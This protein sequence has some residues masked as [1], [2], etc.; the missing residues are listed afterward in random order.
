[1]LKDGLGSTRRMFDFSTTSG[2]SSRVTIIASRISDGKACVIANYRGV[3]PRPV[4]AVYL[5]L[6]P[7]EY[8]EDPFLWEA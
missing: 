4:E 5:F 2:S 1:V 7:Q 3:G 8:N 6:K